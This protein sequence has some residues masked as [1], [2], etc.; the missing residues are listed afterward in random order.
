M[1]KLHKWLRWRRRLPNIR[2]VREHKAA[3][4]M[5][6][7][8]AWLWASAERKPAIARRIMR[9]RIQ[10][11]RIVQ[12]ERG[13]SPW[14]TATMPEADARERSFRLMRIGHPELESVC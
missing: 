5:G 1:K 10:L 4:G 8:L 14:T 12:L 9:C 7:Y 3:E 6:Y 11:D 2:W 13:L